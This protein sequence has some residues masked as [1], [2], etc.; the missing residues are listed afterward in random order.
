MKLI[1]RA[2]TAGLFLVSAGALAS[3][4][5]A[6]ADAPPSDEIEATSSAASPIVQSAGVMRIRASADGA[7]THV[8]LLDEGGGRVGA[9]ELTTE[10]AHRMRAALTLGG[11]AVDMRWTESELTL[12][13]AG[14]GPLTVPIGEPLGAG[15][16]AALLA[17]TGELNVVMGVARDL[18]AFSLIPSDSSGAPAARPLFLGTGGNTNTFEGNDWA[19]GTGSSSWLQAYAG[20]QNAAYNGCVAVHP[21]GGCSTHQGATMNTSC[22]NGTLS[23]SCTTTLTP[24]SCSSTGNCP[25]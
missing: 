7:V 5:A 8:D 20:S 22:S 13:R 12:S 21:G 14:E 19:W 3:A 24:G 9:L 25:R 6:C 18:G 23:V 11:R 16:D 10:G 2:L 4:L 1:H 17:A 15:A